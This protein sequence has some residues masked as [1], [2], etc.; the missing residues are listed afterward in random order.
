M[1]ISN[2]EL[3]QIIKEELDNVMLEMRGMMPPMQYY[4]GMAM[5]MSPDHPDY[6]YVAGIIMRTFQNMMHLAPLVK[7]G[8]GDN[9]KNDIY[10]HVAQEAPEHADYITEKVMQMLME[11]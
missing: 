2:K 5:G 3:R 4:S 1:K 7:Q 10:H 8:F 11:L 9:F 6:D